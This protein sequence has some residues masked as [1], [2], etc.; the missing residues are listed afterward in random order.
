MTTKGI[1]QEMSVWEKGRFSVDKNQISPLSLTSFAPVHGKWRPMY[2]SKA[3]GQ[4][5]S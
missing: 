5:Y 3:G 1:L 4:F 2:F